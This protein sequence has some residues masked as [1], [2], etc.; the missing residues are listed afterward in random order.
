MKTWHFWWHR[1]RIL[2]SFS[3]PR[4]EWK[5][6]PA[7]VIGGKWRPIRG[8]Y[9]KL[10]QNTLVTL[11]RWQIEALVHWSSAGLYIVG[12]KET[13]TL[14]WWKLDRNWNKPSWLYTYQQRKLIVLEVFQSFN[15]IETWKTWKT[16]PKSDSWWK[17]NKVFWSSIPLAWH[18]GAGTKEAVTDCLMS[19]SHYH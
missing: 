10:Q 4:S 3:R 9:L 19:S 13:M 18:L 16:S 17:L 8:H 6:P 14:I 7:R 5:L 15:T 1:R 11:L 12:G 2:A